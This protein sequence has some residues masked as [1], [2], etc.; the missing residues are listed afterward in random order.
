MNQLHVINPAHTPVYGCFISTIYRQ[1]KE[2]PKSFALER[3]CRSGS[4]M[5]ILGRA[6]TPK[7]WDCRDLVSSRVAFAR[8]ETSDHPQVK[9]LLRLQC[10]WLSSCC[11]V[12]DNKLIICHV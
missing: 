12:E 8:S 2:I 10:Q 5:T 7:F 3:S 1:V 11:A 6:T 4:K 9:L